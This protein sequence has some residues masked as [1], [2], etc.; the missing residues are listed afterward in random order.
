MKAFQVISRNND[1]NGN[2]FRMIII[3]KF[4]KGLGFT[5][6]VEERSSMP[7]TVRLLRSLKYQELQSFHITPK[8]YRELKR[9]FHQTT[10]E[11]LENFE[12]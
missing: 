12:L 6:G 3:Y 11:D 7:D 4:F 8:E 9:R 1:R 2:P 5:I 10:F